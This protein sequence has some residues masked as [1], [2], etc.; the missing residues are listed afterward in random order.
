M[1]CYPCLFY[2]SNMKFRMQCIGQELDQEDTAIF[3]LGASRPATAKKLVD[4]QTLTVTV[5]NPADNIII[6]ERIIIGNRPKDYQRD[7]GE[8]GV[9]SVC[10]ELTNGAVMRTLALS[11]S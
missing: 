7:I 4:D 6:D 1:P 5:R 11:S 9:H 2:V 3:L 8:R 10:F